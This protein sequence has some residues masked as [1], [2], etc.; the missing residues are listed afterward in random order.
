MPAASA[1]AGATGVRT[2][3]TRSGPVP[4][5][6]A[7]E[8]STEAEE[9][10]GRRGPRVPELPDLGLTVAALVVGALV[11]LLGVVLTFLGLRGCELVTGTDSCGGP[12]LLVL[13]AILVAMVLAGAAMLRLF[14]VPDAG[15]VSFLGVGVL[16]VVVL[17][18]LLDVLTSLVMVVVIPVLTA[19]C[20][21]L[22]RWVTTQLAEDVMVD[23]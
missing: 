5:A 13:V 11:G 10:T 9:S 17:V 12:G 19:G 8:E 7:D 23:R 22:A 2:T 18:L 3:D 20:Y 16:T 1:G 15:S 6:G 21:A 4:V 14:R